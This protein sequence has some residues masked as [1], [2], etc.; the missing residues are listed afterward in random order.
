MRKH[1]EEAGLKTSSVESG[2]EHLRW[3]MESKMVQPDG[4][5]F[6]CFWVIL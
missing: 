5:S 3:Q 4:R 1:G 2:V 6:L